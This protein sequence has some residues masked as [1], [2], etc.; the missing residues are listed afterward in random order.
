MRT[1]LAALTMCVLALPAYAQYSGGSGTADDPYQIATAADLIALGETP[2]DYDKHFL[3][4]ADIDLDPNLPG[5]RVFDKAP[6][7]PH[8]GRDTSGMNSFKGTRFTGVFDGKGHRIL[9]LTINGKGDLGLFGRTGDSAEI[10]NVGVIEV[11]IT[12]S[13]SYYYVGGLVGYN[14]GTITTS[15][16]TG[17]INGGDLVGGLVGYNVG[18]PVTRCYSTCKVRGYEDVGGLVGYGGGASQCYS[19]GEVI[20]SQDTGGV[21]GGDLAA[22]AQDCFWDI[23]TSG[24]Y[25]SAGGRGLTT[26]QMKT[27]STF[28]NA[29]WDFWG[30]ASDGLHEIWQMPQGGGY[31]VLA[32]FNGYTPPEPQGMGTAENPYL[33]SDV[34]ELGATAYLS[35]RAHYRLV[36]S[37]DLSGIRWGTAVIDRF[38]GMFD[39][40][41]QVL[42]HLT[43]A[44][45]GQ[46]G[47]F[48]E[49]QFGAEVKDL[50]IVDAN[51]TGLGYGVG[52]LAGCNLGDVTRCY[53]TGLVG[54][55]D[56]VGGL[57]GRNG[58]AY[59]YTVTDCSSSAAVSGSFAVGGLV[60]NNEG[61]VAT[62]YTSGV[63]SGNSCVGGLVGSNYSGTVVN[64]HSTGPVGGENDVGGLVGKNSQSFIVAS[65]STG[66]VDA[67]ESVGGLV[68][69]NSEGSIVTSH[70]A[71]EVNGNR[72]V[73]GLIGR[74]DGSIV[75]SYS[76]APVMGEE[77]VGGLVGSNG[78]G[79]IFASYAT[80]AVDGNDVVGG[81]VGSNSGSITTSYSRGAVTGT[82][83]VGGLAG[84]DD[85]I[86]VAGFW[87]ME[88]SGQSGS[89][90]GT[91][92][93]TADMQN[94]DA[95]L[96]EG[97][98]LVD[99]V[100]NGTCDFWQMPLGGYPE[101]SYLDGDGPLM[102]EGL[103][104]AEDPYLIQD[105]RDLGT[106]WFE[107]MAHYR[108]E[109]SLDLSGITWSMAVVPWFAGILDGNG[110]TI[111]N[112][113]IGG[114]GY[115]AL[116]GQLASGGEVKTLGIADCN[117][118]GE[119][120]YVGGLA[121]SN[122]GTVTQCFSSGTVR[123]NENVGG[124]I[125]LNNGVVEECYAI[126]G[127]IGSNAAGGLAGE[128]I[129]GSMS[130]SYSAGL[131]TSDQG[132]GGF[133][134]QKVR[135][136]PRGGGGWDDSG[137]VTDCFWDIETS[138]Q[139]TSNGGT[140]L[141]TADMQTADTFFIWGISG[142]EGVWTIDEGTDY[143]RLSWENRP[144]E[145]IATWLSD[146]LE[147]RGTLEDPYVIYTIDDVNVIKAFYSDQVRYF[148]LGFLAGVG[149]EENPYVI[150]TAEQIALLDMCWYGRNAHFRLGF[151]PGAGTQANP[152]SIYTAEQLNLIGM[153][154]YEW[155]A[156]FKL[157]ADIDLSA[158][159]GKDGRPA[160]NVIGMEYY[161]F[162]GV[163]DGNG[164]KI[165]RLTVAGNEYVGL[166]GM[167][168]FD[169]EVRDLA[170]VDANVIGLSEPW[171]D[172]FEWPAFYVGALVGYNDGGNVIH[173]YSTGVVGGYSYDVGGLIGANT[174]TV[175]RCFSTA[176]VSGDSSVG[177]L[178]GYNRDENG[179]VDR[180][181]ST[182]AVTGDYAVGG[183]VGANSGT[184]DH[185]YSTGT[186]DGSEYVGGLVGENNRGITNS[187]SAGT[188]HGTVSDVGG[189]VGGDVGRVLYGV[190][191]METSGLSG[192]AGGVGLTT[193]EM[194]DPYM[195]GLNG[196]GNDPNWILD[197]SKDYPHLAWEG[198]TGQVVSE[199]DV[200]WLEGKGTA[201]DPYRIDTAAQ[202][203]SLGR[204]GALCDRHFVLGADIDLDP[205]LP[206]GQAFPQAVIPAFAGVLDGAG[207][208]V[209]HLTVTGGTKLGL[210]GRLER[211]A[212]VKNLGVTDA[213][214]SGSGRYSVYAGALAGYADHAAVTDCHSTGT[215]TG[216]GRFSA[217]GGL[218]G[219]NEA[220][221]VTHCY[222]NAVVSSTDQYSPAGG[223]IGENRGNVSRCHSTG[224]VS[225]NESVGG[226]VGSNT[227]GG[228]LSRCYCIA[229]VA[230]ES[231][232]GG[233]V[234]SNSSLVAQCYSTGTASGAENVGGLAGTNGNRIVDSYSTGDANG[235]SAVGGLVGY[236]QADLIRCYSVGSVTDASGGTWGSGGLAGGQGYFSKYV[237]DCFWD[238]ET[239]G[240]T[241][242][243]GG[244]GK[245]TVEMQ[246]AQIF[247][248]AGWDFVG[249]TAN[250]TEDIWWILE[251]KDYPRLWWELEDE[252]SP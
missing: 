157:M 75:T 47:L 242:S 76:A 24:L 222:S 232:V 74:N 134:G 31:P 174:G 250:G 164:H 108:L 5:R 228:T 218:L 239:S 198:T 4:T 45:S 79:G 166:F 144:G 245:T 62:S 68:G 39:G 130:H 176:T 177:G 7:A 238:T 57:V 102:P 14:D 3:L 88:T 78:Q 175:I 186:I 152:Y 114:A 37:L 41:G 127:V 162:T 122:S 178:I 59:G 140:G 64:C 49:L 138:G 193:A 60:G 214:I 201:E 136:F 40:N 8:L 133:V 123:G 247:L 237:F 180:C 91:G 226:L 103:G 124:M 116:F 191:N 113:N 13:A 183:V 139:A 182:G 98:D 233:L 12:G 25:R 105:A 27:A 185:C 38:A 22:V 19:V 210:F 224:A 26:A 115:L 11:R 33:I 252:A 141:T 230:G 149:T 121:G 160:F 42:S 92:L 107:P 128:N 126:V 221:T 95:F 112:L 179:V 169:A 240:L 117:I 189:L 23:Q 148:R 159:D 200:D 246:T 71:G 93:T 235:T 129:G 154:R 206:N 170:V 55:K 165:S 216:G 6:L 17:T 86:I 158:V 163:F 73:G 81:L 48:G 225:G 212:K 106:V 1:A 209:S 213:A 84:S 219:Y 15:F 161:P 171:F 110:Y 190:W 99:E 181:Y 83:G 244:M 18:G 104:T 194:M 120:A 96:D 125:G 243:Y 207:H 56:C 43:I 70:T 234:G 208:S 2:E 137:T 44:A 153:C 168:G 241:T 101:L 61:S 197:T 30:E 94:V 151:V 58:N 204:A 229:V 146:F 36:D 145:P 236:N 217:I 16:S 147:G 32:V 142:N 69:S 215:I 20:G 35:A 220:G 184:V 100:L 29:G 21:G 143:P 132:S 87:D 52:A 196:F 131:V 251:G 67:N 192:S 72:Y 65:Y 66:I 90:G 118:A 28:V 89:A 85:G 119:G 34:H 51:V 97:W 10:R 203:V 77:S 211:G 111:S 156:D 9:H 188:V 135:R 54:G 187:Y 248:D 172:T 82:S 223:L 150:E 205:N 46:A 53:S 109:S 227:R 80:G 231:R 50:G 167:L 249:E 202:L 199:P 195:L 155:D 173:C 63:V